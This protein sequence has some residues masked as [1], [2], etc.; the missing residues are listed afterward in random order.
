MR[1]A[2]VFCVAFALS[3][4]SAS[5]AQRSLISPYFSAPFTV[6]KNSYAFDQA[7]SWAADGRVL[8]GE[9]DSAG[10]L[11]IYRAELDGSRQRCLTCRTV[12]G[13]N[14]VPQ[15]RPQRDWILFH[16]YGQQP[17]HTGGPGFGGYGGDLYAMRADGSHAR[18]LT[19]TSDPN[20]GTE[21]SR[22]GGVPYDNFHAFWSPSGKQMVWTHTEANAL[23]DGGQ[24][25]SMLV[26][27]FRVRHGV[28]SLRNVRVVG[29]PYGAYE[30]QPWAPD[31][32][33]FLFSAAGGYR[34]PYQS[35]PP[36]WG[37]MQVYFMRLYGRGASP[38]HPR[39]TR[40]SDNTPAYQEQALFTPDMKTVIMMSNRSSSGESWYDHVVAAAIRTRFD[41][42][43]TG[44]TQTLQFL[45]DFVGPDFNA[46]LY[47]VDVKTKATR[48]LTHFG[49][50]VVPEFFW[51]RAYRRIIFAVGT[52]GG[53]EVQPTWIGRFKGISRAERTPAKEIPA[54]GLYGKPVKMSRVGAQA[55]PIRDPGP[56][57]N[58]SIP[59]KPPPNPAPARPHARKSSDSPSVPGVTVSYFSVWLG[60]LGALSQQAGS[61]FTSPPLLSVLGQFG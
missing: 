26:G 51:D 13:P 57:D 33:G 25:W 55:Q 2:L 3:A 5:G 34:S 48:Q 17:T 39:V 8:S 9:F 16:S 7:P 35:T 20:A 19:T 4:A 54:A 18:R 61:S 38:Q 1:C 40:I 31:G 14:G 12:K 43:N 49:R 6:S 28:P 47:A 60:D 45:S 46:D 27:D 44:S 41:A 59:V 58:V 21:Y 32:S 29:R 24:A 23:S 36:G 42:P 56:T 22:D 53:S 11:Q 15:E 10:V 30:T 52:H 50:G 37:H